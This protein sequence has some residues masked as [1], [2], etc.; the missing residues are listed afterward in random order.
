M[1]FAS[2]E[3]AEDNRRFRH[4]MARRAAV[5]GALIAA[6]LA[7]AAAGPAYAGPSIKVPASFNVGSAAVGSSRTQSLKIQNVGNATL[8]GTLGK[9]SPPFSLAPGASCGLSIPAGNSAL[10]PIEFKPLKTGTATETLTIISNDPKHK[11]VQVKLS[12]QGTQGF[13]LS[14]TVEG[15][16]LGTTP[17]AGAPVQLLEVGSAYGSATALVGELVTDS[18]GHFS[19]N[20]TPP[21]TPV[22][23]YVTAIAGNAIGGVNN[24]DTGLMALVGLSNKMSSTV[25]ISPFT[26]VAAEWALAQFSDPTGFAFGAPPTNAVAFKNAINQ[27]MTE[28]ANSDTGGPAAFLP[29]AAQCAGSTPPV[30]CDALERLDTLADVISACVESPAGENS[31]ACTELLSDAGVGAGFGVTM[32]AAHEI[33]THP[34]HNVGAL[35]GLL[36]TPEAFAPVLASAPDGWELALAFTPSSSSSPAGIALDSLGNV[37]V[38]T[39]GGETELPEGKSYAKELDFNN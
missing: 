36:S 22:E 32:A 4:W 1:T 9:L 12:G 19:L 28:L 25:V 13:A 20:F 38:A 21:A 23:L 7:L 31:S 16:A 18:A 35:Y 29:T 2:W 30:N 5:A 24:P 26:T 15:G 8:T 34:K 6:L 39:A 10:V 14:G 11:K 37:W 27:A 17:I 3:A 33:V